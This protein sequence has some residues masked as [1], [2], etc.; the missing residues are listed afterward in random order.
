MNYSAVHASPP[1]HPTPTDIVPLQVDPLPAWVSR[2]RFV[3]EVLPRQAD[4][5]LPGDFVWQDSDRSGME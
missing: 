1:G 4:P 3:R 5:G 2:E